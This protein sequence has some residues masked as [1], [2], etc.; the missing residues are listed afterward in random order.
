MQAELSA[1]IVGISLG[2]VG[3]LLSCYLMP[4]L[5]INGH[6]R[7]SYLAMAVNLVGNI[8][9]DTLFVAV[10]SW[11]LLGMGLATSLSSLLCIGVMLPVFCQK[12]ELA[13]FDPHGLKVRDLLDITR[14]GSPVLMFHV[15]LFIKNYGMNC[16]LLNGSNV[17]SVAILTLQGSLCGILGALGFGSGTT[18]QM[19]SSFY[20][21]EGDRE[22]VRDV[23]TV[24]MK[25]GLSLC[26]PAILLLLSCSMPLLSL[27]GLEGGTTQ[28]MAL[29]MLR[30]LCLAIILNLVFTVFVKL[31]QAAEK[32]TLA[33]VITFLENALQGVF[34]LLFVGILGA[35]AAWAAFPTATSLCLLVIMVYGFSGGADC[36]HDLLRFLHFPKAFGNAE[37]ARMTLTIC[38]QEDVM[39]AARGLMDFCT[40][41]GISERTCMTAGICVEELAGNVVK[42]GFE[43]RKR[44]RVWVLAAIQNGTLTLRIR[45]NCI[46]FDPKEYLQ[47]SV[48]DDPSEHIGIRLVAGLAE[49]VEYQNMFGMN[50]LTIE[51]KK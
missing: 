32:L 25:N 5:Q 31:F 8:V 23:F 22:S 18:V 26:I 39:D 16:A 34:A 33:N 45:D 4:F 1:Y 29:R 27:F 35:D 19:L 9:F 21:G 37:G 51:V 24:A 20:I 13:H 12:E 41:Q 42:H 17:D 47:L 49:S 10:L 6:N 28:A 30:M 2:I 15:G 46:R 14:I 50:M 38:S 7:I 3:Q 48:R 44:G 40:E 11:G 36:R 43:D